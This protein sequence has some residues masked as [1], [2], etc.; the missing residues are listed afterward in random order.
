M[1]AV[2]NLHPVGVH[3]TRVSNDVL[4]REHVYGVRG[5]KP[6]QTPV[7]DSY[8]TNAANVVRLSLLTQGEVEEYVIFDCEFK[9]TAA[10][11]NKELDEIGVE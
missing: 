6:S 2:H 11:V 5:W 8:R 1:N 10:L 9:E 7:L 4:G 3:K